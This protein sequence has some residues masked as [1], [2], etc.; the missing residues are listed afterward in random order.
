MS[1]RRFQNDCSV[2]QDAHVLGKGSGL[3]SEYFITRFE[4]GNVFA[5][6]FNR[7]GIVDTQPS[8]FWFAQARQRAQEKQASD[9]QVKRIDCRGAD[10]YQNLIVIR[11][12]LFDFFHFEN[13]RPSI[14]AMKDRFHGIG[15]RTGVAVTFVSRSPIGDEPH[16][17]RQH[18]PDQNRAREPL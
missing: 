17:K 2:R 15:R 4:V 10:F 9:R 16:Q 18:Q 6:R 3:S 11:N 5:N 1:I 12:R 13:L 7:S 14:F 8:V